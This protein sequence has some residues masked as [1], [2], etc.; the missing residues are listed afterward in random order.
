MTFL[1]NSLILKKYL[2]DIV[3]HRVIKRLPLV[4]T[5]L[6]IPKFS[7]TSGNA[8][9]YSS[10]QWYLPDPQQCQ[11]GQI[12]H[13]NSRIRRVFKISFYIIFYKM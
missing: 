12:L 1:L 2:I 4:A 11:T 10:T 7:Q 8:F 13:S 9:S 6:V 5:F 3:N